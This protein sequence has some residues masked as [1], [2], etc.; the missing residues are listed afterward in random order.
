[1]HLSEVDVL[2]VG[3][4]VVGLTT[5]VRLAESG[6]RVEV[7]TEHAIDR[8]TSIAAGAIWGPF[9]TT[10]DER[11]LQWGAD[12]FA[13]LAALAATPDAGVSMVSGIEAARH[14]M[15]MPAWALP[16]PQSRPCDIDE[17]PS[18]YVSGWRYCAPVVDMPIHMH[19]LIN[20]FTAAGGKLAVGHV[21]S[22]TDLADKDTIVVNCTG[23][24]A[25]DL[26][27]DPSVI[28]VRGQLVIVDNPG[29]E[30]FFAEF[31]EEEELLYLLPQGDKV[32]LG[33]TVEPGRTDVT[34]DADAADGIVGRCA[35]VVPSLAKAVVQ[36]HRVGVRPCRPSVRLEHTVTKGGH[37][38]H[39]Y[40]HGGSGV[41]LAWACADEVVQIVN[42]IGIGKIELIR[43][44]LPI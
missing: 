34:P 1:M 17:L 7:R 27:P 5:A 23:W 21:T 43:D 36:S 33:G 25:R 13:T 31:G 20:R 28:P 39:N 35:A 19:Y 6:L 38:I 2:V 42:K 24:R 41:S 12:T 14:Q 8:T 44:C 37:L 11:V 32:I 15:S 3:A 4:G 40:G 10:E 26:V 29:I 16:L 9:L 18:G 22:L 30:E